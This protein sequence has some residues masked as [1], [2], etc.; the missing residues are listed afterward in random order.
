MFFK[1]SCWAATAGLS[2]L[3]ACPSGAQSLSDQDRKFIEDAAKGGMQE[4]HMGHLAVD[5][6]S[7][8]AVK[9]FGQRMIDDH[10]KAS[11]ELTALAKRKGVTLPPDNPSDVPAQLSAK[12]GADFDREYAKM[13]VEDHQKDVSEFQKEAKQGSDPDVKARASKTLPTL[14]SHLNQAK[15]LK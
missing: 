7:S 3:L 12:T 13:M 11:G 6:G 5:H 2:L 14:Q 15:T 4:V 9:N 8:A 10:S 1:S